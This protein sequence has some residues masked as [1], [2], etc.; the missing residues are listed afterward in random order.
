MF[1][2]M[3]HGNVSIVFNYWLAKKAAVGNMS[4]NGLM[5]GWLFWYGFSALER[6][7]G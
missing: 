6:K 1:G 5:A 4:N 7:Q 3:F 2:K